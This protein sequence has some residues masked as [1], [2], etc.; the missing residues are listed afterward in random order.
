MTG[1]SGTGRPRARCGAAAWAAQWYVGMSP[2]RKSVRK[3]GQKPVLG[4][5]ARA[6]AVLLF[7]AAAVGLWL[8]L[9]SMPSRKERLVGSTTAVEWPQGIPSY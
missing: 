8:G 9:H 5:P 4:V 6:D 7:G 2:T 1:Q 3:P